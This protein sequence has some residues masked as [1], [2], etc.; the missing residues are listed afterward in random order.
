MKDK[1]LQKF[2]RIKDEI[3]D[4]YLSAISKFPSFHSSHEGYAVIK[5]EVDELWFEIKAK[6][7]KKKHMRAEAIQ[8][9]A[10]AFRFIIDICEEENEKRLL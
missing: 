6:V 5:E 4:E 9:A 8:I 1:R 3:W 7:N 10:M 2:N